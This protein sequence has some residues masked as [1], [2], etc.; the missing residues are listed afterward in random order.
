M[1]STSMVVMYAATPFRL[2]SRTS[3]VAALARDAA[4]PASSDRYALTPT[5]RRR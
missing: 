4:A 2:G 5:A 3:V 1:L